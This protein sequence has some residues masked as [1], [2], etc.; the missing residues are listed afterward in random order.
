VSLTAIVAAAPAAK[1]LEA[2]L[3]LSSTQFLPWRLQMYAAAAHCFSAL[4]AA[5][6]ASGTAAATAAVSPTSKGTAGSKV[7]G[8]PACGAATADA[9]G[10]AHSVGAAAYSAQALKFLQDGMADI[11]RA[12]AR[13][14]LDPVPPPAA[15]TAALQAAQSQ[16]AVLKALFDSSAVAGAAT[17]GAAAPAAQSS[18]SLPLILKAL[19]PD[20]LKLKVLL[21][22]LLSGAG[23]SQQPLQQTVLP[24]GLQPML[25]AAAEIVAP[26]VAA[27]ATLQASPRPDDASG[28]E[29]HHSIPEHV[30]SCHS[31]ACVKP[32]QRS[33]QHSA[34]AAAGHTRCSSIACANHTSWSCSKVHLLLLLFCCCRPDKSC[35]T[36]VMVGIDCATTY[37]E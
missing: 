22:L 33:R 36:G 18:S 5:T 30:Q 29:L 24:Q 28:K 6:A 21:G 19:G 10:S 34:A 27:A 16:F 4:H 8:S 2:H 31:S 26:A 17:A 37:G 15:V 23:S 11:S 35:R 13:S 12:Q 25:D 7:N 14:S 20:D 32:V 1:A 9:A 3:S